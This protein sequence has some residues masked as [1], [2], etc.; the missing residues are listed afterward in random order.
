MIFVTLY[1]AC[2]INE[3][4]SGWWGLNLALPNIWGTKSKLYFQIDVESVYSREKKK[5]LLNLG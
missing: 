2:G 5:Q 4:R 3:G 1:V